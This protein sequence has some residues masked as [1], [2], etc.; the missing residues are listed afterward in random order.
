M[1]SMKAKSKELIQQLLAHLNQRFPCHEELEPFKI[2][3][4]EV[5]SAIRTENERKDYGNELMKNQL[6]R[7][8]LNQTRGLLEWKNLKNS[9]NNNYESDREDGFGNL[10]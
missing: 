5:R 3:D 1:V 6:K 7:C 10:F 2:L 4:F 8:N 9:A